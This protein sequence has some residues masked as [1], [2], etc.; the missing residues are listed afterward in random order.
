M[1]AAF[2]AVADPNRRHIVEV[3]SRDGS[4]TATSLARELDISRQAVAKH[5]TLLSD[6]G[7]AAGSRRGRETVYR[8]TLDGLAGISAWIDRVERTWARRLQSLAAA[9][10]AREITRRDAD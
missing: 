8:P 3:L 1:T 7:L 6:A 5:L 10:E 9:A 4:A 2:Q